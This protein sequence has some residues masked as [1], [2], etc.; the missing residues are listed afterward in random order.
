MSFDYGACWNSFS[1]SGE[2]SSWDYRLLHRTMTD[3][4]P[5]FLVKNNFR[6]IYLLIGPNQVLT[7]SSRDDINSL[8]GNGRWTIS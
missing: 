7:G 1:T 2:K 3:D 4:G 6:E 5:Q 8:E